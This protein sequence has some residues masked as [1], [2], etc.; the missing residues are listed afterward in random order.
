MVAIEIITAAEAEADARALLDTSHEGVQASEVSGP[1]GGAHV[2]SDTAEASTDA[3]EGLDPQ[4]ALATADACASLDA[5]AL[6]NPS[7]SS[8]PGFGGSGFEE[9]KGTEEGKKGSGGPGDI[10]SLH[11]R[12]VGVIRRNWRV[13]AGSIDASAGTAR[14]GDDGSNGGGPRR[15]RGARQGNGGGGGDEVA[16]AALGIEEDESGGGVGDGEGVMAGAGTVASLLFLPVNKRIPP[17][18]IS[19]RRP[20]ILLGQR[21]LV[22]VDQWPATSPVPLGHYVR[23]LG[24]DGD[25]AVETQ[26][27]LHEFGEK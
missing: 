23:L 22:A 2:A 1:V 12:V 9:T 26:V 7:P 17:I 19:T 5:M 11:G 10:A 18:R 21:L 3:I 14:E 15:R 8:M 25:K 16:G 13:Y 27:L 6:D 4:A 24:P 20:E